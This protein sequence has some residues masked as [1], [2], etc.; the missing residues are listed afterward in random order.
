M[1]PAETVVRARSDYSELLR[2]VKEAG[3]LNR[4]P[5]Y[6]VVRIAMIAL[7][8]M[9]GWVTFALL[10]RSWWQFPS[11]P[12]SNLRRAQPLVRAF[13]AERGVPCLESTLLGSYGQV[14]RPL[15]TIGRA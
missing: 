10:G 14:L 8:F 2:R 13:C 1:Q 3:L 5:V 12:R 7:L 15:R 6:Y 11:M 9:G 4:R